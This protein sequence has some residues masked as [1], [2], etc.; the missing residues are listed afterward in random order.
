MKKPKSIRQLIKI[1]DRWFSKFIRLRA[2]TDNGYCTCITCGKVMFWKKGCHAGHFIVRQWVRTRWH[3]LNVYP[4]CCKCN[5]YLNGN[6]ENYYSYM[7]NEIGQDGIDHLKK[8]SR[9]APN[10]LNREELE[11]IIELSKKGVRLLRLEKGL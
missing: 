4:Q 3:P 9:E 5:L 7:L 11:A 2:A 1:A 10:S 6:Y 8:V